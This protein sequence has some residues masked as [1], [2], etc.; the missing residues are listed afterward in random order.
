MEPESSQK[1]SGWERMLQVLMVAFVFGMVVYW[2]GWV[3][4]ETVREHGWLF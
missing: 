2:I 4:P 3:I 1:V